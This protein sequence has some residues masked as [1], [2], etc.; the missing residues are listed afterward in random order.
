MSRRAQS[1]PP[2]QRL[3]H[4]AAN[5]RASNEELR[6]LAG[7]IARIGDEMKAA[8]GATG[9]AAGAPAP[10]P[11]AGP[12]TATGQSATVTGPP[13]SQQAKGQAKGPASA[14]TSASTS[15][16]TSPVKAGTAAG[17]PGKGRGRPKDQANAKGAKP[18]SGAGKGAKAAPEGTAAAVAGT[19][20]TTPATASGAVNAPHA[21]GSATA[22]SAPPPAAASSSSSSNSN[23]SGVPASCPIITVEFRENP[24]AR[25]ILPLWRPATVIERRLSPQSNKRKMIK[26]T[27]WLPAIGSSAARAANAI[28][29][30]GAAGD[31]EDDEVPAPA[32]GHQRDAP[33]GAERYPITWTITPCA[34]EDDNEGEG[35][36]KEKE[37]PESL[38]DAFGRVNTGSLAEADNA[39][40]DAFLEKVGGTFIWLTLLHSLTRNHPQYRR[41]APMFKT[42]PKLHVATPSKDLQDHLT[43]RFVP[44]LH[45]LSNRPVVRL[46]KGDDASGH[47]HAPPPPAQFV[48]V[49]HSSSSSLFSSNGNNKRAHDDSVEAHARQAGDESPAAAKPKRKRHVATHNPDG[50]LKLCQA[51]GTNTT[52]MWRRG[53]AGK[54]T[55]CNACGAKWKV[56]RLVVSLTASLRRETRKGKSIADV[57][58]CIRSRITRRP[59]RL[60]L[61][62]LLLPRPPMLPQRRS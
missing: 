11:A 7:V 58:Y 31:D 9:S 47:A 33:K 41:A 62:L 45:S 12:A 26:V 20:A 38:W 5:G 25:F 29:R 23:N 35:E 6:Q 21:Q 17:T 15:T 43:D 36:H 4:I 14:S 52:P 13:L 10:A 22:A 37:I 16:T 3:L 39:L 53:P 61:R 44:R 59:L 60:Q 28:A 40:L 49:S 24:S 27:M 8:A 32:P 57:R 34:D 54:S 55:L 48:P 19:N 2:L 46:K 50:T 42:T 1:D 56:G 30:G 18:P 51:C